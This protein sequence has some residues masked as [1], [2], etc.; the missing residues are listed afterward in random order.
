MRQTYRFLLWLF[1]DIIGYTYSWDD[2]DRMA[3]LGEIH[4]SLQSSAF[5]ID[6]SDFKSAFQTCF[7]KL[8]ERWASIPITRIFRVVSGILLE[9]VWQN[10]T[11]LKGSNLYK[12]YTGQ[13]WPKINDCLIKHSSH[14]SS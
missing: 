9:S 8:P 12:I 4:Y 13:H 11:V 14:K 7:C 1:L 5:K 2:F 10:F 3:T 6:V